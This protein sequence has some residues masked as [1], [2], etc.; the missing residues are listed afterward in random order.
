M[1]AGWFRYDRKMRREKKVRYINGS[2]VQ[3]TLQEFS[4][5][6]M[7]AMVNREGELR[8]WYD[9]AFSASTEVKK[10]HNDLGCGSIPDPLDL[11]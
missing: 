9:I 1:D 8:R 10:I 2:P 3:L 5:R 11:G 4:A 7:G 6:L